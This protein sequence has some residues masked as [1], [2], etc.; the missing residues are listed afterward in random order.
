M[1]FTNP[2]SVKTPSVS[3]ITAAEIN[4]AGAAIA[5]S[6]DGTGG[7][8]YTP[9]SAPIRI[10]GAQ[11]LRILSGGF[12]TVLSG[13]TL[14]VPSGGI[15]TAASGSTVTLAGTNVISGVTTASD[16]TMTGTSRIKLGSRSV[17]RL[18]RSAPFGETNFTVNA[19]SYVTQS[20][21][22]ASIV[23]WELDI[24]HGSTLTSVSIEIQ[25][26]VHVSLPGTMP[27]LTVMVMAANHITGTIAGG[28]T[29][30]GSGSVGAYNAQHPVAV[31]GLSIAVDRT[32][33]N[34]WA[35]FEGE[36]GSNSLTGLIAGTPS[37]T[38]TM[39]EMPDR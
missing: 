3:T 11:G 6:V 22:A 16:L 4:A 39:T 19:D 37:Y 18:A 36:A 1:A 10:G 15:V 27:K 20:S 28:P 5:Q 30:D 14:S 33:Y 24:P 12:L 32:Q 25:P 7:G 13:G 26:V 2:F 35:K 29:S 34:Y 17:P 8:D 21:T 31:S 38:C 9:V 23:S